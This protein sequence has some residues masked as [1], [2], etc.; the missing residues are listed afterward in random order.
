MIL[1]IGLTSKEY[2]IRSKAAKEL[3]YSKKF[4]ETNGD[5]R[6]TWQVINDLASRNVVNSSITVKPILS[7]RP[8]GMAKRP[9]K[10]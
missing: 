1:I 2:V 9:L 3:F 4:I 8:R 10:G 7:G 6:K 5:P